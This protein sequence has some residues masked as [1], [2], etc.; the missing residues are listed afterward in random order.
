MTFAG[1]ADYPG[2]FDDYSVPL[3]DYRGVI[4]PQYNPIA[5]AQYGLARYNRFLASA[6]DDD[7]VAFLRQADWLVENLKP[8]RHGVPVWNHDFDWEYVETLRNPW[9]SGLA[10]GQGISLLV[11]AHNATDEPRYLE[12]AARAYISLTE[13]TDAGGVLAFDEQGDVWIEEYIVESPTH[14]LNGFIWALW[15]VRDYHLATG[16]EEADE[17]WNAGVRT[18]VRNL[19]SYDIGFWS[20]YDLSRPDGARMIASSFYHRLHVA[21]LQ[22]MSALT[23]MEEF[24]RHAERWENYSS[25]W[26]NRQRSLLEK[27]RFK[28]RHY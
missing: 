18:L 19:P 15:G 8:N 23:G 20:L 9:Y 28:I 6:S 7:R 22:V 4:G 21:Q 11:R 3:L 10:Q 24:G 14:I 2:P 25:S 12:S 13:Q 1:K 27:V 5:I 26:F 17:L 16:N